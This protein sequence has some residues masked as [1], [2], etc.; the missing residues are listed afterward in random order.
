MLRIRTAGFFLLALV[1]FSAVRGLSVLSV[2]SSALKGQQSVLL[3]G[4]GSGGD[5]GGLKS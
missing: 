3:A 5:T 1:V 2:A 4:G